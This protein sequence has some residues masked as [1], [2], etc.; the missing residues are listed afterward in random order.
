[1]RFSEP[2][3]GKAELHAILRERRG[4]LWAAGLFSVLV[5]LLMLTGPLF[6]LQVYDRVLGSRS[7]E[8]LVALFLLMAF[9]FLMMGVLDYARGRVLARVGAGF[10]ARL[11]R[12]VFSAMLRHEAS[13]RG[14]ACRGNN[15]LR[16]LEAVQRLFAAPVITAFFDIPWTPVFLAGILI[17]HPWLGALA[18]VGGAILIALAALNQ[19]LTS[20]LAFAAD[21]AA[22]RADHLAEDLRANAEMV[23]AL[24]MSGAVFERWR[25]AQDAALDNAIRASDRAGQFGSISKSF[26]MFLQSAMLGLGALLVLRGE[27]SA[28]A[29]IAASILLGRALAP[30][31]TAIGH[32]PAV[33]RARHGWRALVE[34]L[35]KQAPRAARLALPRPAAR[36]V[37][38]QLSVAP[39]GRSDPALARI[40]FELEPGRALGV[41]GPSGAGKSSLARAIT[42]AWP[43][44]SGAIRLDGASLDQY[45]PEALGRHIGYLPQQVKLFDG[46]IAENIAG[47][48][49][50]PDPDAVVMAARQAAA[51]DL[52]LAL[53][54]GYDT[55][56]ETGA[57][58]LSGG[59]V[60]RIALAR[61]L[62][63]EPVILV[64]DEPNANLDNDGTIALNRAIRTVKARGGAVVIMAHRPAAITECELLMVLEEGRMRAFGPRDEVLARMVQNLHEIQPTLRAGQA[65]GVA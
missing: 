64:L 35:G 8:T 7:E 62:F 6:M 30:V 11:D 63:G 13:Q 34:L 22:A 24:G 39:A 25:R 4:A 16:D 46:T 43:P 48:A 61:A 12:R 2:I 33:Q 1:M 45:A 18:L 27:L 36:L 55:L 53:P 21:R 60:Q 14:R 10:R 5:N 26:R 58:R 19:G 65:G 38:H 23:G 57:N 42:G 28:G 51:H 17:F 50:S 15:T 59:Q 47:L 44:R 56:I 29:M 9:L 3:G 41:I 37:A 31:E 40:S 54:D 52:I 32:W 20:G 49:I